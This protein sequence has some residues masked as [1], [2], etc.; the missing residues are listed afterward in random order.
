VSNN[1]GA[2]VTIQ[3]CT[4]AP[5]QKWTFV[6]G[7]V[8]VFDNKCLQLPG[9]STAADGTKLQIQTCVGGDTTQQFFYTVSIQK[10]MD[11]TNS[12]I[13]IIIADKF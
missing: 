7:S 11:V 9:G 8:H 3:S 4:D 2:A 13:I 10:F 1:D 5:A 12:F 6:G